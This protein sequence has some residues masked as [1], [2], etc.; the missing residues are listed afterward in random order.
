MHSS[1]YAVEF[2]LLYYFRGPRGALQLRSFVVVGGPAHLHRASDIAGE[3]WTPIS[4]DNWRAH[5]FAST[6]SPL[7]CRRIG[8]R[9]RRQL[10][11]MSGL[12]SPS[13]IRISRSTAINGL[14]ASLSPAQR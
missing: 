1:M 6:T 10:L 2:S 5:Y 4:A 12:A 7:A 3:P 11:V 9:D 13:C 8:R 14:A